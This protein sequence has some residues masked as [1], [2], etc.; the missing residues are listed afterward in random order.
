M[1]TIKQSEAFITQPK[2]SSWETKA[3]KSSFESALLSK[4]REL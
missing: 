2:D 1:Q 4:E 3:A